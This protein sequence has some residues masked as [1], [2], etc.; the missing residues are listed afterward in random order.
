MK[1]LLVNKFHYLKGGAERV[2]FETKALLEKHGHEVI[3]FS[4]NDEKNVASPQKEYFVEHTDFGSK[5]NWVK[6]ALRYIYYPEAARKLEALI[7]AEK[8]DIAHLH[9]ISHYLTASILKPLKKNGIPVVQTL[10]DYQLICPN[11]HLFV[12]NRVCERCKEHKYYNAVLRR[13]IRG[14]FWASV[15]GALELTA[16]WIFRFYREN[17]DIFIAPSNFLASKLKAWGV[18]QEVE[19]VANFVDLEKLKPNFID[20]GYL[21]C[22]SRLSHEKGIMTLI[23]AIRKVPEIKLKLI[24]EGPDRKAILEY[25]KQKQVRNVEYLGAKFGEELFEIVSKAKFV[26]IPSENYENAPMFAIEAMAL[27]KPILAS[28]LGGL[29]E[30]VKEGV[31]GWLFQAGD[32]KNLRRDIRLHFEDKNLAELGAN[33]RRIAEEKYSAEKHCK[34]LMIVYTSLLKK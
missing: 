3:C 15:L 1:I 13:C 19:V 18:K 6:K 22:V 27:G 8:P 4:M 7:E 25:L 32:I 34:D 20:D 33:G 16:Q 26:V 31:N 23:R 21:V 2:Y 28:R 12:K 14:E 17:V 10:H 29:A 9:N 30:M 11:Y 24:G 5:D